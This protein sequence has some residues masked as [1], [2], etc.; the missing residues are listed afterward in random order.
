MQTNGGI[1]GMKPQELS[2]NSE[3]FEETR[4]NLDTAMKI[5]INRMISTRINKGTVSLKIGIEIKEIINDDG[6]V[7][8]M[9]EISYNIGMGMTEKDS[10][11][12]N[13]QRGL[14]LKRSSC[15]KLFV[16][17]EQISMEELMEGQT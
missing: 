3:L 9:P 10:M 2:I 1:E 12:G 17:T 5:L 14:M 16:S 7:I 8:R 4:N 11:K 15:G 6:E 13:I